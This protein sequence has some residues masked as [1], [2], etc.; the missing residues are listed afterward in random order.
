MIAR[1][2]GLENIRQESREG[3][4]REDQEKTTAKYS[5]H[6]P[7]NTPRDKI[8]QEYANTRFAEA[9]IRFP[10]EI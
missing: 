9:E 8:V 6:T 1:V 7:L 4:R 5:E 10:K 2:L 3:L